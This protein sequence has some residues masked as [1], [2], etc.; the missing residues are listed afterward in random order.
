MVFISDFH[1]SKDKIK[2][3]SGDVYDKGRDN[4]LLS[5]RD[6]NKNDKVFCVKELFKDNSSQAKSKGII[7]ISNEK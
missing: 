1:E 7:S 5:F 4:F 2:I 3:F 6:L